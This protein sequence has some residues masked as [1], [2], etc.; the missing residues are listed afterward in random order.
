LEPASG[1]VD[2]GAVVEVRRA[3]RGGGGKGEHGMGLGNGGP[4]A[5][6]DLAVSLVQQLVRLR[7]KYL[8][9]AEVLWSGH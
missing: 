5:S 8:G 6:G 7:G 3:Y 9:A 4:H 2:P 1:N